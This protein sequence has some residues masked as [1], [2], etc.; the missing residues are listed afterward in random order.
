MLF[1]PRR[2]AAF[3]TL[4]TER[5]AVVVAVL[6]LQRLAQPTAIMTR[7]R[8]HIHIE[9]NIICIS[10][11]CLSLEYTVFVRGVVEDLV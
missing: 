6:I 9:L 5:V 7:N 11:T 3:Y 2:H 1:E 8:G 10:F 4:P